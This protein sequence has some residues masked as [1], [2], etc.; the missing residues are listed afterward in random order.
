[1]TICTTPEFQLNSHRSFTHAESALLD[2]TR[3][4]EMPEKMLRVLH[5]RKLIRHVKFQSR[6]LDC[7]SRIV[8]SCIRHYAYTL[9]SVIMRILLH[10][11]VNVFV[12]YQYPL[13]LFP[14]C[15]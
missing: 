15:R 14:C 11:S 4:A 8:Y 3:V 7:G 10:Q 1:M 6:T 9:A 5:H 13:S 12:W 2:I